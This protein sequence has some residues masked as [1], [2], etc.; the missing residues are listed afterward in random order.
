M[1]AWSNSLADLKVNGTSVMSISPGTALGC[2]CVCVRAES[3]MLSWFETFVHRNDAMIR[4]LPTYT[5]GDN[6]STLYQLS[7]MLQTM[8]MTMKQVLPL[9]FMLTMMRQAV[10]VTVV[11]APFDVE[12]A[13]DE[14]LDDDSVLFARNLQVQTQFIMTEP[15]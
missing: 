6:V 2:V 4:L 3:A 14:A 11:D 10:L 5:F 13:V 15:C 8:S 12:V 7:D 9:V 1:K